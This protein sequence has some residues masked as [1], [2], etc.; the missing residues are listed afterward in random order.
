MSR[1]ERAALP[2][3]QGRPR[4]RPGAFPAAG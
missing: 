1:D 4:L 2:R 3:A